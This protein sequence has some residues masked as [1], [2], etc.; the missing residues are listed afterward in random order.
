MDDPLA[1]F[2]ILKQDYLPPE[3]G[4]RLSF[5]LGNDFPRELTGLVKMVAWHGDNYLT[6]RQPDGWWEPGGKLEPGE[7]VDK[8]IRREMLE[9]TG[10]RVRDFRVFGAFHCFSLLE[11]PPEA[12]LLWPEF[13]FLWGLGEVEFVQ[14]PQ[15]TANEKILEVR[16]AP[17]DDVCALLAATPGAGPW[18]VDIYRLAADLRRTEGR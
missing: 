16:A 9:E 11:A 13:Y 7:S 10:A 14:S 12:S 1:R 6:I 8:A 15:P 3:G 4:M 2:P 5:V 17:L 18:L